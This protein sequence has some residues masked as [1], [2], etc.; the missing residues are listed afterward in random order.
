MLWRNLWT[1]LIFVFG[2]VVV[3]FLVVAILFL[4]RQEYLPGVL[5]ILATIVNGV[6]ISWVVTRRN[7]AV[8]EEGE[9]YKKITEK[10]GDSVSLEQFK[11]RLYLI[12]KLR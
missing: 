5:N 3:G 6:A 9:A 12:G 8:D 1:I 11:E 4:M 2:A 10:C 7:Q